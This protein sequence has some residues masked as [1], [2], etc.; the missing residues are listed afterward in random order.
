M[1]EVVEPE[2]LAARAL[3]VARSILEAPAH[4]LRFTKAYCTSPGATFEES[5]R[6]EHDRAFEELILRDR[7]PPGGP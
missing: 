4:A 2:A 5:F 3:A 1:S 7:R 6:V